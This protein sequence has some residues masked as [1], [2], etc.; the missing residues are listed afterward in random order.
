MRKIYIVVDDCGGDVY[1]SIFATKEEAIKQAELDF[2]RLT[3][4]DL[5]RRSAFYVLESEAESEESEIFFDGD[6]VKRFL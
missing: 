6:I 1:T 2:E 4:S 5:R 3:K